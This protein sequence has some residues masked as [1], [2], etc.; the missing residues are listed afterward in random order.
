[1]LLLAGFLLLT[2][3]S[4]DLDLDLGRGASGSSGTLLLVVLV[5]GAIALSALIAVRGLRQMVVGW[6]RR[7]TSEGIASLRGLRSPRRLLLL[8]GGNLTTE[9]LFALSLVVFLRAFG[10]SVG[11]GEV[12]FVVIAVSL[13]AGLLPVPGGIGVSEGGLI[14]GL[15]AT[16]VPEEIAFAAV[17]GYRFATFYLPPVWGFFALRWL[18]RNQHL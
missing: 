10:V 13:L 9:V 1:M 15:I 14:Y 6:A 5:I 16:G 18:E 7:L 11:L 4:L 17:I 12:L 2:P 3:L 8:F